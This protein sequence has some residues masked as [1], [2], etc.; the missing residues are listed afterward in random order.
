MNL[1]LAEMARRLT[2]LEARV[3]QALSQGLDA[4]AAALELAASAKAV[5]SAVAAGLTDE[6]QVNALRDSIG[7]EVKGLEAAIGSNANQAVVLELGSAQT[8]PHP[9]LGAVADAQ[10]DA[11]QRSVGD[12]VTAVLEGRPLASTASAH[13]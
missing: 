2:E 7:R 1:S 8:P 10:A 13:T 6:A 4:A 3:P 12:A 9:F 11:L 5:E